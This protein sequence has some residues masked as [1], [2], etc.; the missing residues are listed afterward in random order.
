MVKPYVGLAQGQSGSR[1]Q[2]KARHLLRRELEEVLQ[3][4]LKKDLEFKR[5]R[6]G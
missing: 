2:G 3:R 1:D 4:R 5:L 6:L